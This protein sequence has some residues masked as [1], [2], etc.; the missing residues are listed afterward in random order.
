LLEHWEDQADFVPF[1]YARAHLKGIHTQGAVQDMARALELDPGQWR[2]YRDL[3]EIYSKDGDNGA[4]LLLAESAHELFPKNYILE[5]A[6]SKYLTVSGDYQSSLDVLEK[7]KVLP[8]EGEN[9]GQRLHIYN[10]LL[11]AYEQYNKGEY[12]LALGH[13]DQSELY[14]E[15]LGSGA[16][17][18]P[19][20]RDQN[21]LRKMIYDK[22]GQRQLSQEAEKAIL[23]YTLK[24]GE[25]RGRSVFDQQFST[26]VIQ[27]F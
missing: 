1:Y 10:H 3:A 9:T 5:L 13:I 2:I 8:F 25:R 14:P 20:C 18:Y 6:Y 7:A 21:N 17:S 12:D 22:T 19:D 23:D 15:N 26:T 24:F 16:P 4:A 11:L 27:P